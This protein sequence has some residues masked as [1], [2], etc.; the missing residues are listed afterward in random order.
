M[1]LVINPCDDESRIY[2]P[3]YPNRNPGA[4][5]SGSYRNFFLI[6]LL[7]QASILR[8]HFRPGRAITS[9]A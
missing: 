3:S 6:N 4:V 9:S 2:D 7:K 8:M 1:R 5:V